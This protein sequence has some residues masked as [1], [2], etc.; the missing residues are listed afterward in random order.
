[1]NVPSSSPT[2]DPAT[3][4][5]DPIE[6]FKKLWAGTVSATGPAVD[7]VKDITNDSPSP[8]ATMEGG[9]LLLIISSVLVLLTVVT[10]VST[11]S[12]LATLVVLA[13]LIGII[14]LLGQVGILKIYIANG[15][16][17]VEYH[18]LTNVS[19][20]QASASITGS[21]SQATTAA[22]APST[23]DQTAS[24][25]KPVMKSEVFHVGGNEYTYQDAPAVC[26][27]YDSELATYDQLTAA[28]ALGAEW[29][30]YGW[31]QGGM[32]LF[33][34]QQSTW[35][36][37]QADPLA[38]TACGRPGINGGYFDPGTKFGVNCYGPKPPDN[39]NAKYPLPVPGT[40]PTM[41]NQL[42]NK[43][44]SQLNTMSVN[45]FNRSAWSGWNLSAH[46]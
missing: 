18:E 42:V 8:T 38:R 41:F 32:A 9:G 16:L 35:T 39:T 22:P 7:K 12:I 13:I 46:T 40:D 20:D 10:Y 6:E 5:F 15:S 23:S 1:M 28:L 25:P 24:A 34:T 21:A 44:K 43:F 17:H 4:T 26:A 3:T 45:A 11:G 31:S 33:P 29:C 2:G 19:N 37:L 30:A 36:Q 27:A 14:L